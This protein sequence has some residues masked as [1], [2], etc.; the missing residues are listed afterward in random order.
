MPLSPQRR[1]ELL[2]E[3]SQ[4]PG[5]TEVAVRLHELLVHELGARSS[6]MTFEGQ[7]VKEVRGRYDALLGQTIFEFKK[8]LRRE[9]ADAESQLKRYLSQRQQETGQRFVGIATDGRDWLAYEL[10]A[11]SLFELQRL[12]LR[13]GNEARLIAF[14]DSAVS[15]QGAIPPEPQKVRDE[16]GKESLA[17]RIAR[18]RLAAMWRGVRGS[19]EA[20]LKRALWSGLMEHVYGTPVDEDDLFFQHTYLTVVA[21]TM[22]VRVLGMNLPEPEELLSGR[23][24]SDAGIEGVVESDFFDWILESAE[25]R[26]LISRVARQV[27]RFD[28]ERVQTDVLKGLYE[29]LIDPEQRHDLGEYY[30]PDWLAARMVARV[31]DRP[32]EQ[33]VLDPACGSGTFL[34]HAVRHFLSAAD[35]TGTPNREAVS[36]CVDMVYGIDV[37]PVAVQIARITYLL[38]IGE[39]RLRDRGAISIPVY[40]GDS[41]QWSTR[42][43]MDQAHLEIEVPQEESLHFPASVTRDAAVFDEVLDAMLDLSEADAD[44]QGLRSWLALRHPLEDKDADTLVK[45]YE[46]FRALNKAG[47]NH[48][49]KYV[50]RNQSKPVSLSFPDHRVDVVIGNPPWLSFRYMSQAMQKRF[51]KECQDRNIWAGGNVATHQDLSGYF[52][53]RSVELYLKQGGVIAFV[54]PYA[55][56]NRKQFAGFR[57]GRFGA[58]SW[59]SNPFTWV[60]FEEAWAM[61]EDVQPL[62]PVPSCVLIGR[63]TQYGQ[64]PMTISRARGTLPVR[65]ASPALAAARLK[66]EEAPWPEEATFRGGSPYR[67]AFRQG[68]TMVPR[69]LCM[70]RPATTGPLGGVR[71]APLVESRRTNLEKEPWKSL[72]PLRGNVEAAFLRPLCLGESIAPFRPLQPVLAVIPWDGEHGLLDARAAQNLGYRHLAR[73]LAEA[74]RHWREKGRSTSMSLIDRWDF[75]KELSAQFPIPA[76]RVV[77]SKAG[78]QP[79]ACAIRDGEAVVDHKLYWAT[80]SGHEAEYL[81][82]VL[83]SE[84]ARARVQHLQARGQWGARD[85]DKLMFGLPI[86]KFDES[87]Q[88]H[89]QLAAAGARA[90]EVAMAVPLRE[91]AHFVS[92]RRQI[93]QALAEDGVAARIEKL[94]EE[95]LS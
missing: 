79:A 7:I 55:V 40:L 62:F 69:V 87:K 71:D 75:N 30:T 38:A 27:A 24:F 50:A 36:Q 2:H 73:W 37:H 60:R 77:Y 35:A 6:D 59:G 18:E 48:I 66:W 93:R 47:K 22:A 26:D 82:S 81:V 89:R 21:K 88:L 84:C 74:E 4:R 86:P 52:F 9:Q 12:T 39:E 13:E 11:E 57:K 80:T 85:F 1:Q 29:S 23:A 46:H 32:L 16:L 17:Y 67:G 68:A 56:L 83:N 76:V 15:T 64:L 51:R 28:L 95:L 44:P 8:D 65:D 63:R 10:R 31:I 3:L 78:T 53:V 58:R 54:M 19:E 43:I 34:F 92:A 72:D 14:L 61:D 25:S 70:V 20:R 94:V 49:W 5:H 45:A 41:L 33:R 90:E 91:G 42:I